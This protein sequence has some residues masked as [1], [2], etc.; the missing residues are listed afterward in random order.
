[1]SRVLCFRNYK[2]LQ[3]CISVN[4]CS[5]CISVNLCVSIYVSVID[6]TKAIYLYIIMSHSLHHAN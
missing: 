5:C 3:Y 2:Y 4:L 6:S 1:M